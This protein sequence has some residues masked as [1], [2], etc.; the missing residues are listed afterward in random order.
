MSDAMTQ[1]P[2]YQSHKKVWALKIADLKHTGTPDQESDGSLLMV[3]ENS[4]YAPIKLDAAFVR[5]HRPKAGGYWV[6]YEGG[7]TSFS[8]AEAFESGYTLIAR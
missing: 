2:Q 8:P 1:L 5:K 3:P 7:Y 6:K 4:D